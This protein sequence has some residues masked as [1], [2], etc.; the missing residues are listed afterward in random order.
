MAVDTSDSFE[1]LSGRLHCSACLQPPP[2]KSMQLLLSSNGQ[3]SMV[4]QHCP[5][6][7]KPGS[8]DEGAEEAKRCRALDFVILVTGFRHPM[9]CARVKHSN[10]HAPG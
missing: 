10:K 3:L 9:S 7:A 1:L 8:C 4:M 2:C 6:P 5:T